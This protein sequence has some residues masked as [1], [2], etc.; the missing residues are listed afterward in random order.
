[1][2]NETFRQKFKRLFKDIEENIKP[3]ASIFLKFKIAFDFITEK[4]FHNIELIDYIQ[5]GFFY[6]KKV[7]RR[8]FMTHGELVRT[9]HAC[10][11]QEMKIRFDQKP[12]FN[13]DFSEFLGRDWLDTSKAT[14]EEII[15]FL[16]NHEQV[17]GKKPDG[18]FGKGIKIFKAKEIK[19]DEQLVSQIRADELLLEDTLTQHTE[20]AAFNAS[21]VNSMRVVTLKTKNEGTKV[22][23][24][25]L[26]LGRTGKFADNFHHNGIAALIDVQTGIV[27]TVGVDREWNRY[28]LH[29]DSG[30]QIVGFSIPKW[31][32]IIKI[33]KEAAEIHP[34]VRYI[35]WD[36]TIKEDGTVVLI[37]GNPGADPDITQIPDQIG[38]WKLFEPYI[39]EFEK[40]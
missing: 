9:I 33:V 2:H 5:Y 21:S 20:L 15:E 6:K 4:I 27:Y 24:A 29:P 11:N 8:N 12:L 40:T 16:Q 1:M 22:M 38:K 31:E 28:I 23:A 35:G 26:R 39:V 14:N 7:E 36:V 37:E 10:N 3:N 17:F 32:I 18:M 25:V 13:E 19:I 34:D 30:K